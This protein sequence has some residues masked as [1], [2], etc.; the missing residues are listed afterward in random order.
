MLL[1]SFIKEATALLSEIYPEAEAGSIVSI[2]LEE[3][4]GVKKYTHIL[5]PE[6]EI[7]QDRI[8]DLRNDLSRLRSSEPLQYV[9]GTTLF[10]GRSF[11]VDGR[12]LIPRPETEELVSL[13]LEGLAPGSKVMD[14]CTGSGCIAWSIALSCPESRVV[15]VDISD[16]ALELASSQ[17]DS[18]GP[19]FR[20]TDILGADWSAEAGTYD[21]VVSNPPYIMD[22]QKAAM[23][24]NV[25]DWEPSIALFVPDVDPLV[26]YRAVADAASVLLRKGGR[27]IVEINDCLPQE[28]CEVFRQRG[29]SDVQAVKDIFGR[30]RMVT[31]R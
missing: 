29:F 12:V 14:L 7:P 1:S 24:S 17:F 19:E 20:K 15:A 10:C 25:L 2:L 26:F 5:E 11:K 4:L 30:F 3:R 21:L 31:F 13:A 27:G 28:T 9:L 16:G 18:P 23:R 8:E 6:R 22:S